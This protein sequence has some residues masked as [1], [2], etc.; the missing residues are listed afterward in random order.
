MHIGADARICRRQRLE[1]SGEDTIRQHAGGANRT[2]LARV[3]R[4]WCGS[5]ASGAGRAR[6]C[7]SRAGVRVARVRFGATT[8]QASL[9]KW[10]IGDLAAH[11]AVN[12]PTTTGRGGECAIDRIWRGQRP[13][14]IG[15]HQPLSS[16]PHG[17]PAERLIRMTDRRNCLIRTVVRRPAAETP[18]EARRRTGGR[19]PAGTSFAQRPVAPR[20]GALA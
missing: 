3:A 9:W 8:P 20:P 12:A 5:R 11:S 13:R 4:E 1:V 15:R 18:A 6:G 19:V 10:V 16:C 14:R 2:R 7:G 17:R